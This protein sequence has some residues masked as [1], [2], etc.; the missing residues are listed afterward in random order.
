[1]QRAHALL[2]PRLP[3]R[4]L[5][6]GQLP[7]AQL[8]ERFIETPSVLFATASFWEGVD[9]PGDALSLVVIDKLPFASPGDPVVSARVD[10]IR[11]AGG[12]AFGAYQVP[13]AAIALRQGFGRL[14][15][16]RTDRGIVAV[17]DK[18]IVTKSYGRQFVRSLPDCP[19]FPS[20]DS[21]TRWWNAER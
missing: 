2:E 12:D 14:I 13:Q 4:V 7:K 6:Q 9:V 8:I 1:M 10:A 15:R 5:L 20:L 18:R 11:A 16:S 21:V 17:L 3:Y 19:R